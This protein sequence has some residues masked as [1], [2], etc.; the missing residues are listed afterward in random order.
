MLEFLSHK[1]NCLRA[2][3]SQCNEWKKIK[4]TKSNIFY[5]H[6]HVA[7]IIYCLRWISQLTWAIKSGMLGNSKTK[8]ALADRN[9]QRYEEFLET[10][11]HNLTKRDEKIMKTVTKA[12]Y[13]EI[14]DS[15]DFES[16][17][18]GTQEGKFVLQLGYKTKFKTKL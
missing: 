10:I 14:M 4:K 6:Y 17:A 7:L 18:M 12:I 15:L 8:L 2:S 9:K 3:L 13:H 11:V 16:V 1:E 5:V